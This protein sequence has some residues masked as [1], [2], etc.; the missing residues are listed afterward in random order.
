[1]KSTDPDPSPTKKPRAET[2]P[3][4]VSQRK[5]NRTKTP[6]KKNNNRR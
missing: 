3:Q 2:F 4:K 1:M 5:K 6:A